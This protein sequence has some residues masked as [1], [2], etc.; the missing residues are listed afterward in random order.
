MNYKNG[1]VYMDTLFN[2][3]SETFN[4]S[5]EQFSFVNIAFIIVAAIFFVIMAWRVRSDLQDGE[6]DHT[7]KDGL[8]ITCRIIVIIF[9]IL[10]GCYNFWSALG[11]PSAGEQEA[12]ALIVGYTIAG[13]LAFWV[14]SISATLVDKILNN[15]RKQRD[16]ETFMKEK[17]K[18]A[19]EATL[20]VEQ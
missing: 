18:V 13:V 20:D 3:A 1:V 6:L 11:V 8:I 2:T 17:K 16:V 14:V 9:G 4:P 12:N 15:M 7:P 19:R 5:W 10:I